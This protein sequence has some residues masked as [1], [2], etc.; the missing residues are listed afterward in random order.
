[1][2][3]MFKLCILP[4]SE[5]QPFAGG[6]TLRRAD[7]LWETAH[8]GEAKLVENICSESKQRNRGF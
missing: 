2:I 6:N 3:N 5:N 4:K 8:W 1:M 7:V